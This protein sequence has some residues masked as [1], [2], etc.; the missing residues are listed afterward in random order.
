MTQLFSRHFVSQ[1][2]SP[3]SYESRQY[4]L[5][6]AFGALGASTFLFFFFYNTFIL[7]YYAIAVIDIFGFLFS[8]L[9]MHFLQK[10]H[11]VQ[12][13]T[14]LITL[15]Y[16]LFF[17]VFTYLNKNESFGLIWNIFFCLVAININ[18]HKKGLIYTLI[19]YGLICLM[20]HEGIGVWQNGQWD[21]VAFF[22]YAFSLLLL[23]FC[24]YVMELALFYSYAKLRKIAEED[25]LTQTFNRRKLREALHAEIK[26][27][28]RHQTHLSTVLFDVDNF[29]YIN[30]TFGHNV[31]DDVLV[32]LSNIIK[33][34]I[35]INDIFG[36]WGGEE[37]L[38]ILPHISDEEA[39][40][41][42]EKI[43]FILSQKI[44]DSVGKV[45]CSFG[46]GM[47]S[48]EMSLDTL[49]SHCDHAMYE[50]KNRGKDCVSIYTLS[51][52]PEQK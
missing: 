33:K 4:T 47:Y 9:I 10:T 30:D 44:F 18:G 16:F 42:C 14:H 40:I 39:Y 17:L 45:S 6:M 27:A 36:R 20:A 46:I 13:F 21:K 52:E 23:T 5:I 25:E 50:A 35:R 48:K 15:F 26:R 29:K 24:I 37:F 38:L 12:L 22:R 8:F 2:L 43:R 34:T 51:N 31:G 7:H 3:Y 1:L 19:L 28:N 41:V 32:Q 11:K 49:I